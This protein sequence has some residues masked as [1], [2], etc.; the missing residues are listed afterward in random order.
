VR[1]N[2]FVT[3]RG[4]LEFGGDGI[5]IDEESGKNDSLDAPWSGGKGY[6]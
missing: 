5:A 6:S 4:Q 3:C 1:G 2:E